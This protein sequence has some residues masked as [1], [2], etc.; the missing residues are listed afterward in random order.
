MVDDNYQLI[1]FIQTSSSRDVELSSI[2]TSLGISYQAAVDE[3]VVRA[4]H[5]V[6][7]KSQLR[8]T[9]P[10]SGHR[11]QPPVGSGGIVV[12]N[13]RG[14]SWEWVDDVGVLRL[15]V[16]LQLPMARDVD[17]TTWCGR[18]EICGF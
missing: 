14:T 6:K 2:T 12:W 3:N 16:S 1:D 5:T 11:K 13:V 17:S 4:I 8:I 15:P 7:S 9:F 10:T 18:V